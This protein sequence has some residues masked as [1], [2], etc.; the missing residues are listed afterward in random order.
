MKSIIA[1]SALLH[2]LLACFSSSTV[3]AS[4]LIDDF[5]DGSI[6]VARLA[7][8]VEEA[9]Q[10][11][12][13]ASSVIGG[14]RSIAVG[15]FGIAPQ[16]LTVEASLGTMT[17]ETGD[18]LGY[19]SVEYG[20]TASPLNLDLL[21]DGSNSFVLDFVADTSF[22]RLSVS[23]YTPGGSDR[24]GTGAFAVNPQPLPNGMTRV[25][26]PFELYG[27]H[28]DF[29]RVERIELDSSRFPRSSTMSIHRFTTVPEPSTLL[30]ASVFVS[31]VLSRRYAADDG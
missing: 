5:R 23:V 20:S 19:F 2:L 9:T 13:D 6:A 27:T 12:L 18:T 8:T 10:T 17:F 4:T 11:G 1:V 31:V 24:I 21:R 7:D 30:L 16:T 26:I 22:P 28:V 14:E 29:R 15:Q 25:V 3:F